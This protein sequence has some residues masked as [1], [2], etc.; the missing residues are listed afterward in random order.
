L[1]V[2]YTDLFK[3]RRKTRPES[4]N[5]TS[6]GGRWAG[7]KEN[8]LCCYNMHVSGYALSIFNY[9]IVE[10]ICSVVIKEIFISTCCVLGTLLSA[11]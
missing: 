8:D 6:A 4:G 7:K 10:H 9:I 11:L 3:L 2:L 5:G 1:A